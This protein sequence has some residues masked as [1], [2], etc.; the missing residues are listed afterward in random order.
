MTH[1]SSRA[2]SSLGSLHRANGSRFRTAASHVRGPHGS[3]QWS[4]GT[5]SCSWPDPTANI[6]DRRVRP[7][8]GQLGTN[9]R[10]DERPGIRLPNRSRGNRDG[11]CSHWKAL[12]R[13]HATPAALQ[14]AYF[15]RGPLTRSRSGV[16]ESTT[17]SSDGLIPGHTGRTHN[18]PLLWTGPRRVRMLSYSSARL[19]RRVAGHRASSV[20]CH[21][22]FGS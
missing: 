5:R 14:N 20:M 8:D 1:T 2:L 22:H 12:S 18:Q 3:S 10:L 16:R 13:L 15:S 7:A 9:R 17:C 11:R 6:H 19:A 4:L 21:Q